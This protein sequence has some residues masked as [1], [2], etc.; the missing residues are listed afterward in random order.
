MLEPEEREL[1]EK[2]N[3]KLAMLE[4]GLAADRLM[5]S[6]AKSLI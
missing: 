4:A 2:I 1:Y 3:R 5:G 6:R